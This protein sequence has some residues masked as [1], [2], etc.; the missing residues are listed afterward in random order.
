[1]KKEKKISLVFLFLCLSLAFSQENTPVLKSLSSDTGLIISDSITKLIIHNSSGDIAHDLVQEI[2]LIDRQQNTEGYNKSI[3]LIEKKAKEFGLDELKVEYYKSDGETS[4]FGDASQMT[5][6]VKKGELFVTTPYYYKLT[7]YKELP[8]SLVVNSYSKDTI[9]DLV[10]IGQG[11]D[12]DYINKDIKG[13]IVLTSKSPYTVLNKA[14]WEKGAIGI[15]SSYTTPY[16]DKSNRQ[17]GDYQDQVGW[18]YMPTVEN[19]EKQSFAFMISNRRANE[20]KSQLS[21]GKVSLQVN[22]DT[23]LEPDEFGIVSGIIKGSKFPDEEIIIT[24]HID[25]YK[26]GA[27]DN[28]SGSAVSLEIIRTFK[29]LID[30]NKIQQPLRTIRFL[31][32]PEFTGT[33]AWFSRHLEDKNKKLLFNIN[34]DMLGANL[35]KSNSFFNITYTPDWNPSYINAFSASI[36]DFVN[37]FNNSK[38][39]KRKDYH[40]ISLTG[41]RNHINAGIERYTRGSDHQIFNDFGIPGIAYSTWPDN[42]YHSSE[43]TPD[44]VDATQLHR[45]VFIGMAN[46]I[47]AAYADE[48]NSVDIINLVEMYGKKR[49]EEDKFESRKYLLSSNEN[50]KKTFYFASQIINYAYK[51]EIETLKT[52]L[53]FSN[54]RKVNKIISHKIEQYNL[55]KSSALKDLASL[56]T[57]NND[58]VNK[59]YNLSEKELKANK[60]IPNK[61]SDKRLNSFYSTYG[62]IKEDED[63]YVKIQSEIEKLLS[64]LREREVGELRIYEFEDIILSYANGK[65][66]IID[67]QNALFAAYKIIVPTQTLLDIFDVLKH[68]E[69]IFYNNK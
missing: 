5:W 26:P 56:V 32:L 31:W 23:T 36:L 40:I 62:Q 3:N 25:H 51:R 33:K 13:N 43:D 57:I 67:I 22:V 27:N 17:E 11:K 44:K 49:L 60:I 8:M 37:T 47:M 42:F 59:N 66:T 12:S 35:K 18:T 34:L 20:L 48:D 4:Y 7:S 50:K 1:M 19:K 2:S 69:V 58:G 9:A 55:E 65:N 61:F 29:K 14:V 38:Y 68:A 64:V 41:S 21:R 46:I 30:E 15:I 24:S 16:W 52:C 6:K 54:N 63:K 28:A 45:V 10:D 39:P 53:Q